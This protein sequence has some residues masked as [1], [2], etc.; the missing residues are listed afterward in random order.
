ME[1]RLKVQLIASQIG[2]PEKQRR[3]VRSLGLRKINQIKELADT[4]VVLGM[5]NKIKHLVRVITE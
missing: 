2:R 4:P 3:I 1:S 5:V